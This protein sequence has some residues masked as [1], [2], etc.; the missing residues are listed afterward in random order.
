MV[1]GKVTSWTLLVSTAPKS[2]SSARPVAGLNRKPTGFC[3][4][5]FAARM[6]YADSTVPMWTSHMQAGVQLL[7]EAA[8]AE[9]P[10]A[11]ERG[12]EEEREQRLDRQRRAEDVAD[13]ARVVRPVHPELELLHDAGDQA[14]GEVDE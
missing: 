3:M 2:V 5:E 4:N 7:G 9:D 12:L 11:E 14:E 8:P 10:Q 1:C 6:K 13:E